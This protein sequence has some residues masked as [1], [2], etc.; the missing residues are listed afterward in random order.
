VTRV[1][2]VFAALAIVL[3]AS[4]VHAQVVRPTAPEPGAAPDPK[5]ADDLE[6]DDDDESDDDK[7]DDEPKTATQSTTSP[8]VTG[9][10]KPLPPPG[11]PRAEEQPGLFLEQPR[12]HRH[13]RHVEVGPDF[14]L[15]SRPAKN[16]SASYSAGFGWGAHARI[17]ILPVLGF[18]AYANAAKHAVTMADSAI[19]QP[20]I[21]VLQIG[22]RLE[23]TWRVIPTLRLW[24]G[25]GVAWGRAAAPAPTMD[26]VQD[27]SLTDRSGV[28]L[29]YSAA[30]GG[31]YDVI[32]NWLALSLS[33]SGGVMANQS[34]D[35]FNGTQAIKDDG[36]MS[37]LPGLPEMESSFSALLGVGMIL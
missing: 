37:R 15:W 24:L 3:S 8:E 10:E 19:D 26:G 23:P 4:G 31:T 16:D 12:P 6:L 7:S 18:S 14:G 20:A 28:F 2:G 22:A 29:E 34:G 36:F 11:A 32:P 17:E 13:V 35:L 21:D 25:L 1:R 27:S 5:K 33:V 30:L 9:D